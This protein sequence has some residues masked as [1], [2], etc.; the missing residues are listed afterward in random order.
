VYYWIITLVFGVT[1]S[2]IAETKGRNTFGWFLVGLMIGP[3]ALLV[4]ALPK[5]P[6]D[7]RFVKCPTCFEIIH[8][9]AERCR[10]CHERMLAAPQHDVS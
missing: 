9:H 10:F 2:V 6:R 5:I 7:G 1:A 4:I 8:A 3:F